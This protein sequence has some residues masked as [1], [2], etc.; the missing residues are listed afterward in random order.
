MKQKNNHI[1]NI[2]DW[3]NEQISKSIIAYVLCANV[4]ELLKTSVSELLITFFVF[5]LSVLVRVCVCM[6]TAVSLFI[7]QL[8]LTPLPLC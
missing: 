8:F 5:F 1:C 2:L 6:C 3:K 4:L 7:F